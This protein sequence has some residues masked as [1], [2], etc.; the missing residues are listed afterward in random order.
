MTLQGHTHRFHHCTT[1]FPHQMHYITSILVTHQCATSFPSLRCIATLP[2]TSLHYKRRLARG[3]NKRRFA[4]RASLHT[5]AP[6]R[7]HPCAASRRCKSI[8]ARQAKARLAHNTAHHCAASLHSLTGLHAHR[9]ITTLAPHR[10][11]HCAASHH[12]K[13]IAARQA[14]ARLAHIT[15]HHCVASLHSL[16]ALHAHRVHHCA[17]GEG[18]PRIAARQAN[19]RLASLRDKRRLASP[20]KLQ[21]MNQN[22]RIPI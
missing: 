7:F 4:S 21:K 3:G 22:L 10:F 2:K 5:N 13:N 17:T 11:H 8:A 1:S 18:S 19:A 14:K 20:T 12:C 15:A 16:A 9:C 6:H